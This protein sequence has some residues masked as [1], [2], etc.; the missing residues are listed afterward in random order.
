MKR[1][2]EWDW[3]DPRETQPDIF[4]APRLVLSAVLPVIYLVLEH[5]KKDEEVR[6]LYLAGTAG[7]GST[8]AL[9]GTAGAAGAD[10]NEGAR[11]A[12]VL[13]AG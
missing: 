7:A 5:P 4:M 3:E 9:A 2:V 6:A 11:S 10:N 1:S 13:A 8:S 12:E